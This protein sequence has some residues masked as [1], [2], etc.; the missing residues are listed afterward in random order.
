M[1]DQWVL[2]NKFYYFFR[3]IFLLNNS[4]HEISDKDTS[5]KNR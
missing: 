2:Y 4:V 1:S 5:R 3:K